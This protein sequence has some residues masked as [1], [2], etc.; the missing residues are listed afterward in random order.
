MC[1]TGLC[2]KETPNKE[3]DFWAV[4]K[5]HLNVCSN[6]QWCRRYHFIDVFAGRGVWKCEDVGP[7]TGSP[8]LFQKL[9]QMFPKPYKG[10]II[11]IDENSYNS[12]VKYITDPHIKVHLGSADDIIKQ[13]D[14]LPP[15]GTYGI[16]YCDPPMTIPTIEL[17]FAIMAAISRY[18]PT[19]D[20]MLYIA[21]TPMKRVNQCGGHLSEGIKKVNKKGWVIRELQ[22]KFQYTFLIGTN[23]TKWAEWKNLGFHNIESPRGRKI[24][25]IA[26]STKDELEEKKRQLQ[27][28]LP[29]PIEPIRSI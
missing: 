27:M 22:A 29:F 7:L 21:S 17:S 14:W 8:V 28:M 4:M 3:H 26:D 9:A 10:D 13:I 6:I 5:H 2:G 12:L 25:E 20:V 18:Y 16:A 24:F 11:E 19:V 15:K 1:I 23:W